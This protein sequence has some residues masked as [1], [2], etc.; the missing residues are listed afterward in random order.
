MTEIKIKVGLSY[1]T[2]NVDITKIS[3]DYLGAVKTDL[4][5]KRYVRKL[6][7]GDFAGMTK[8]AWATL[9]TG[10]D[11]VYDFA[12]KYVIDG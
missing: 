3:K 7:N 4:S 5:K 11:S 1:K 12:L 8:Q 9:S 10:N 2:I 6:E